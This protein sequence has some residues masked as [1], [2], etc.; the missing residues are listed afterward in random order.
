MAQEHPIF[1]PPANRDAVLWRYMDLAKFLYLLQNSSLFFPRS[2]L[3]GDPFEGSLTHQ[4]V[5]RRPLVYSEILANLDRKKQDAF[6]NRLIQIHSWFRSWTFVSCWHQNDGESEAM[7]KLYGT[8]AF[9]IA[10]TTTYSKLF[11]ALP[12]NCCLGIVKYIDYKTEVITEENMLAPFVHKRRAFQ[13]EREVRAVIQ[14]PPY[15][16]LDLL[17]DKFNDEPG[18]SISFDLRQTIDRVFVSP[19][20]PIWF[21]QLV[22]QEIVAHGYEI[23]VTPSELI[24]IP[25][26]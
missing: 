2:D 21:Q 23:P 6:I 10:V 20:A 18:I 25:P 9:A 11:S 3:L 1:E 8:S 7:W 22:M 17:I 24:D 5:Q 16:D 15:K 12:A 4:N 19:T 14:E 26:K 13:H